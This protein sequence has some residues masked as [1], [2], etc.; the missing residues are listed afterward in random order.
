MDYPAAFAH[1]EKIFHAGLR[2]V[3]PRRLVET[4][5]SLD[6]TLLTVTDGDSE[7]RL[8]L[9]DFDRIV[10]IGAGK[11]SAALA[12]GLE[13]VLGER[14]DRGLVVVKYGHTAPLQRIEILEAG[15][16]VP[17]ANGLAGARRILEM[18]REA[19]ARTLV[20]GLIS[21]GGSA[22][23]TAPLQSETGPALALADKQETT[24][25]LLAC[26]ASIDEINTLRK[27][28]SA[29]KGGRLVRAL[30]P[31][32]CLNLVLSDVVGDRLDVIASG[33]TVGD[34]STW[35]DAMAVVE[36]YGLAGRL[37][38]TVMEVLRR[39]VAGE[40]EETPGPGDASF[41][42]IDNVL[43]GRNLDALKGAADQAGRLGYRPVLLTSQATGEARELAVLLRA[44]ARDVRG[45]GLL[46]ARPAC[47]LCGGETTVTLRGEGKGGR[48]QELALAFL[49]G[50]RPDS[51][52][53]AGLY[54]LS[55]ATDGDD[56]PTDAAG[57]F[58]CTDLFAEARRRGLD[59]GDYLRR[60]DSYRFFEQLGA[61]LK[62][63]PTNTNVCDLQMVLV[64]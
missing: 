8:D 14:I 17:D 44:V 43:L 35:A 2:K 40:L 47:L 63:G 23:L 10:V 33:P 9:D 13:T 3:D 16:P 6:G 34:T 42:A 55:A 25:Q 57:A 53:D 15:H 52:G 27:H 58:A 39:G 31:A 21:G 41:A 59:P 62:T 18:A 28:L 20:V 29:I 60:N 11:A 61:L 36:R 45:E 19:D 4:R 56:G 1:L 37:P 51:N 32:R 26:G 64:V 54:L 49:A 38:A 46:A 22:L 24:R 30:H 48:N 7:I 5:L 50:L 12:R